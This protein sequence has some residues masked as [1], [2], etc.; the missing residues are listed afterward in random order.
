MKDFL[1]FLN[2]TDIDTLTKIPGISTAIAGNIIEARPFNSVE[3]CLNV[4]GMG[5]NLLARLQSNFEAGEN[6][7]EN[8]AMI[9]VEE[10]AAPAYIEKSQPAQESTK[11]QPSF[12]S[13]LGRAFVSFIRALFRLIA[14]ALVI[15]GIGAGLYYGLPFLNKK[16]V[17]PVERNTVRI[18]E[19]SQQ[20]ESLQTQIDEMTTQ[21]DALDKTIATHS[22]MLVQLGEMQT[23]LESQYNNGN[24]KLAQELKREIKVTRVIEFLSRA[25]LYLSQSNFGLAKEDVQSARDLLTEVQAENPE[26]K[27]D[28]MNQVMARL[29]LALDNLPA[30]PV[31]AVGDV[32]I[33]LQLLMASLPEGAA[34][35]AATP[36]VIITVTS[37]PEPVL[38][39]TPTPTP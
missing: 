13:R 30:F 21:V 11:E 28:G 8:S 15:G 16:L 6:A 37:T 35:V 34:E 29:D 38:E 2:T 22:T 36:T 9:P 27:T 33:A 24:E 26:Y 10:E 14:L 17:V 19:L 18:A 39:V 31:I 3:D 20:V 32:D 7:S 4:R 12:L 5:K 23:S 25:R 1:T